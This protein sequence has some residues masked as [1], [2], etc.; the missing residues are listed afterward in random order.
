MLQWTRDFPPPQ[1]PQGLIRQQEEK[2]EEGSQPHQAELWPQG[3]KARWLSLGRR[4]PPAVSPASLH[5]LNKIF[6]CKTHV[7]VMI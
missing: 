6:S 1:V 2:E 5:F 3:A 4:P 7:S